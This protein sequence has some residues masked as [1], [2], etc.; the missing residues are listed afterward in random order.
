MND[1]EIFQRLRAV[2]LNLEVSALAA[3]DEIQRLHA[4]NERLRAEKQA[5]I[6]GGWRACIDHIIR[7]DSP[8]PVCRIAELK[9]ALH[10]A[11][12]DLSGPKVWGALNAGQMQCSQCQ[13]AYINLEDVIADLRALKEVR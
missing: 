4:D 12:E 6:D 1:N 8:C 2:A 11:V 7:P 3:N 10:T 5:I 9:S 13:Q